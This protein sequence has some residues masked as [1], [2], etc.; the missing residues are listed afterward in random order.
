[1]R[2]PT[3]ISMG[4]ATFGLCLGSLAQSAPVLPSGTNLSVRTADGS[5]PGG[6]SAPD[7]E[8]GADDILAINVWKEPDLCRTVPVRPDGKITMPLIGDLQASG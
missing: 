5:H 3:Y 2:L 4:I 8:I 7:Y 1:M 6:T